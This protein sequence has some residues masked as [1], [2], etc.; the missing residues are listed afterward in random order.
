MNLANMNFAQFD[1][2][3]GVL[4]QA[5]TENIPNPISYTNQHQLQILQP[6]LSQAQG[7]SHNLFR[8]HPAQGIDIDTGAYSFTTR[9]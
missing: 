8:G 2:Q 9:L 4:Q 6:E 7:R 1:A 3:F 5:R